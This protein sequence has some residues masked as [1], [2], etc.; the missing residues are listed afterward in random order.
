MRRVCI[1]DLEKV[2][3][4]KFTRF[5][6]HRIKQ[7]RNK[8]HIWNNILQ[9]VWKIITE[10]TVQS[11]QKIFE[12]SVEM[13]VWDYIK[14]KFYQKAHIFLF[15]FKTFQSICRQNFLQIFMNFSII[16]VRAFLLQTICYQKDTTT[17]Q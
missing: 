16:Y 2:E 1:N 7:N 6:F 9:S 11:Y 13:G 8:L 3:L 4:N 17:E 10:K 5:G 15:D 14:Q 12:I